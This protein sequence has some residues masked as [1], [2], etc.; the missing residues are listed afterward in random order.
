MDD[1]DERGTGLYM[2]LG[3]LDRFY[4]DIAVRI[5]CGGS[6]VDID[7]A[8]VIEGLEEPF[9]SEWSNNV[10]CAAHPSPEVQPQ[11]AKRAGI[12]GWKALELLLGDVT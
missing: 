7:P 1:A 4:P 11:K 9:P 2:V 10:K 6:F 5:C 12:G 8:T 3:N